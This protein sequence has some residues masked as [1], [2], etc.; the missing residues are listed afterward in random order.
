MGEY[1]FPRLSVLQA[2]A[3]LETL[4][5]R[6]QPEFGVKA[7]TAP[8]G[9]RSAPQELLAQ[10][11]EA[12]LEATFEWPVGKEVPRIDVA[13]WDLRVGQALVD[14]M[15]IIT[16]DAAADG[17]W[18]YLTLL[19]M[20]DVAVTRFPDRHPS[21]ML[22]GYRNVF[23][24]TWWRQSVL[25][26]VHVPD[27]IRP[28]GE[29]EL[30]GIFERSKLARDHRLARALASVVLGYQG[31]D[32]SAFTRRLAILVRRE[33]GAR[34]L[35]MLSEQELTN[36]VESLSPHAWPPPAVEP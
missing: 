35:D 18:A 4:P 13:A 6:P 31:R 14:S 34:V 8:T 11:R 23:R 19:I 17:V 12:V 24:R 28:L 27:G 33:T 32:R 29:D 22:G 15:R 2:G 10:V 5:A 1:L 20:P 36:L 3:L 25:E 30:V 21:R 9:G 16:S 26:G 7:P